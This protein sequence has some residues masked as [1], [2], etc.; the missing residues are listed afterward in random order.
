MR[1][2][3]QPA[4]PRQSKLDDIVLGVLGASDPVN[5]TIVDLELV[6][7][8]L[9]TDEELAEQAKT[10]RFARH[11]EPYALVE[12]MPLREAPPMPRRK[13]PSTF[14]QTIP[15]P[16]VL[17]TKPYDKIDPLAAFEDKVPPW[18]TDSLRWLAISV[19]A[20]V[21]AAVAIYV[22]GTVC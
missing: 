21:A 17:S 8:E 1:N 6:D 2:F 20:G 4:T 16:Q 22:A 3:V 9:L 15:A 11:S 12:I 10:T 5:D 13:R 7:I 14:V 19:A 18:R